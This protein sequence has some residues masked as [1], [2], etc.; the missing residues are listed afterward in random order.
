MAGVAA[1]STLSLILDD[2][3]EWKLRKRLALEEAAGMYRHWAKESGR[4]IAQADIDE[5]ARHAMLE[6]EKRSKGSRS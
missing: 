4:A 5:A 6:K 1:G 3:G 2:T